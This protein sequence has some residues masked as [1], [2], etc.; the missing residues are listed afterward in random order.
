M[1]QEEK[2]EYPLNVTETFDDANFHIKYCLSFIKKYLTGHIAE[3]G[4]DVEV[5]HVI[6]LIKK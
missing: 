4:A 3:I 6:I 5:L 1:K 2:Y